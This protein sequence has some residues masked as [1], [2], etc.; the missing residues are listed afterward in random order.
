MGGSVTFC[1]FFT[2]TPEDQTPQPIVMQNGLNDA[3]LDKGVPFGVKIETRGTTWPPAPENHQNL[4]NFGRNFF[5]LDFTLALAV[6]PVNTHKS[7]LEPPKSIIVNRQCGVGNQNMGL[8]FEQG[9]PGT[10]YHD[11]ERSKSWPSYI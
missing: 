7:S 9:V 8:D 2:K 10:W 3:D 6:S 4:A 11:I 5:S 1:F